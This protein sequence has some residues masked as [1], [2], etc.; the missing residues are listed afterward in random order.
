MKNHNILLYALAVLLFISCSDVNYESQGEKPSTVKDLVVENKD[1]DIHVSWTLPQGASASIIKY[2]N[3]GE[4]TVVDGQTSQ[5][6]SNAEVNVEHVITLKAVYSDNR[7][8]EGTTQRITIQGTEPV[9]SLSANRVNNTIV[10]EWK[11]PASSNATNIDIVWN[12]NTPVSIDATQNSYVIN[13]VSSDQAYNI[14][15]R[16]RNSQI[17][18]HY[19]YA[20]IKS[21]RIAYLMSVESPDDIVDDDEKASYNWFKATYENGDIL[22]PNT[23]VSTDLSAYSV[24]WL[25]VDR[26][27]LLPGANNLPTTLVNE[28]I[29][30]ALSAFYKNG[31]NLLLTNHATQYITLLGRIASDRNPGIF[32]SGEGGTGSDV[33]SFNTNI[34]MLYDNIDHPIFESMGTVN[35]FGHPTIPLIGPGHREDHNSM[36]DLNAFSYSVDG[37]N[38]V[39]KFQ[40]EDQAKVLGTWGHVTDFCCAGIVE[41][42]PTQTYKGRCIAIGLAAYEWNQN[43]NI[44]IYQDQIELLTKNTIK[45]L[46]Q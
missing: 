15:V 4:T 35:D 14:G 24:I 34:G 20:N 37:D 41:F 17:K 18:S 27:G 42:Y 10:L 40:K 45:Y 3:E 28:N 22:A 9:N 5:I 2:N 26:V 19:V 29:I 30:S 44:N 43:S 13:D 6:F 39:D 12:D 36:W 21:Q 8:S 31:G 1:G 7:T 32:G 23:V 33:W 25:H 38:V 46:Q 11:I 16:T